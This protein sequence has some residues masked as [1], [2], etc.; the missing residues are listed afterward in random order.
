MVRILMVLALLALTPAAPV[1]AQEAQF[2]RWVASFKSRAVARGIPRAT[3]DR[4]FRGVSYN[5]RVV[6]LDRNQAEFRTSL[7][8]YLSITNSAARVNDGRDIMRRYGRT[9]TA[10]E[11]NYGVDASV[12]AAIWGIESS[13]GQRMGNISVIESTATLAFDGRRAKLFEDQLMAALRILVRGDTGGAPLV[14]S[15]AGAMGHTQF[16]PTS[17]EAYAVDATGDGRRD[18]WGS[19]PTDALASTAAYLKRF[20]YVRGMPPFV[21]VRV[22]S[23]ADTSG[24]RMPSDWARRG[25]VGLDGRPVRDFGAARIMRPRDANGVALMTFK[26]FTAIKRYNGSDSYVIGVGMLAQQLRGGAPLAG[27]ISG[28]DR[29]LTERE[30]EQLQ[31]RLNR[32]GFD[33]GTPDGRIGPRTISAVRAYQR[34][35]GLAATGLASAGLLARLR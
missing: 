6:N 22:P 17:F 18:I 9:L 4:A 3:V 28:G 35:Q 10:I 23:G 34:S 11:R 29:Y 21:Q 13:F 19:D 16:I 27:L 20:G 1:L 7:P 2:Q 33:A 24:Q 14:G 25:I 5:A 31:R 12:V 8:V 32:A 30:A 26:N 15:W